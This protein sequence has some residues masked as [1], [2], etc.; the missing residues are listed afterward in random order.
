MTFLGPCARCSAAASRSVKRPVDSI[1]TSTPRSPH[2]SAPG[3]RSA[4]TFR[5]GPPPRRP[6]APAGG[7]APV[8]LERPLAAGGDGPGVGPEDRVVLEQVRERPRVGEVV[9]GDPLD[10]IA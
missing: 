9:D 10:L 8:Y 1:T 4:S 6:P 3:S 5:S 2:G 7:R